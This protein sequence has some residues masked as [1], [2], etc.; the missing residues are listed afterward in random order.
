MADSSGVTDAQLLDLINGT[1]AKQLPLNDMGFDVALTH[2]D[3]EAVN[4]WMAKDKIVIDSGTQ[5]ER[6]VQL[7]QAGTAQWVH[8]YEA[9]DYN[10][11][12]LMS[13]LTAPWRQCHVYWMIERRELYRNRTGS[14]LVDLLKERRVGAMMAM[15][16]LLEPD[17]MT[18]PT[19]A[20]D[21]RTCYGIQMMI[22]KAEDSTGTGFYGGLSSDFTTVCG[23]APC[24]SD[25][26]TSSI[27]GGKAMWRNYC[28][29]YTSV[30]AALLKKLRTAFKRIK[31][32]APVTTRDLAQGPKSNYR[33]YGDIGTI[34]DLEDLA[35]KRNQNLGS[36]LGRF[37]GMAT[38]ANVPMIA[39]DTLDSDA[40]DPLYMVNHNDYQVF[41]LEGDYLREGDAHPMDRNHN[42]F[43]TDVDL[44]VNALIRNRRH[45]ACI[46]KV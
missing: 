14:K 40:D 39:L 7:D 1:R 18:G 29:Y 34:V 2:N 32:R 26:G 3:Y 11:M 37:A 42:V 43:V 6:R 36:D 23:I 46:C 16:D 28:D 31:F 9:D 24:T 25:S 13:T 10:Q 17:F 45:Q 19:V 38:F 30:N 27:A 35:E 20:S 22:G 5:I 8:L 44:S 41:V 15:A 21:D 4:R 12:D 33:I